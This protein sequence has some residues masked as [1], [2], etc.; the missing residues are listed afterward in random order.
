MS[1]ARRI[2]PGR[3]RSLLAPMAGLPPHPKNARTVRRAGPPGIG[4]LAVSLAIALAPG[5]AR[6]AKPAADRIG[7]SVV[8]VFA[9]LRYPNPYQPWTKRAPQDVSG[10][11][12][13][14]EG[15]RILTNAHVVMYGSDI[16]VQAGGA[17]DKIPATVAAMA[18]GIDLAVLTLQDKSF[19][20]GHPPLPRYAIIPAIKD[21]VTVYGYPLGGTTLSIT[22]GIVS[23]IEFAMY[24]FPVAGLRIQ[25]D[26]AL[27]HGNSGGPAVVDGR[28]IGLA[29][30]RLENGAQNI[31]YIIPTEE[32]DLFLRGI[33]DG[34]YD[35]K[36]AIYDEFQTLNN[37]T[38][39]A[40]LKLP[41][42]VHGV[43]VTEPYGD[44]PSY[45]LKRWDVVTKIG[46]T[47]LDDQGMIDTDTGLHLAFNYLVQ[48]LAKDGHVPLTIWRDGRP[49]QIELPVPT[50]RAMVVPDLDGKYPS[51]FIYGPLVFSE[52]TTEFLAALNANAGLANYLADM[53]SP[54]ETRRLDKPAFPGERLV[55]VSSPFFPSPLGEGYSNPELGVVKTV[56]GVRIK[57][58]RHLVEVL[59][60]TKDKFI[61]IVFYGHERESPVFRRAAMVAATNE[62]LNDNNV[63]S[64]GSPDMMAVW[65]ARPATKSGN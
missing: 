65:N 12:V 38:L 24:H 63:R 52:A 22:Q 33:A 11:G 42:D 3:P 4:V 7:K 44:G 19:F 64:Q 31:G 29:F 47:P 13:V 55:V 18:P 36:P 37:A 62:I 57:N 49:R 28:M 16:Q 14:I 30:S 8:K 60:D 50:R 39:R 25:I 20:A 2:F 61:S 9:T 5:A 27:N 35:G 51:Y 21:T 48:K 53:D 40:Y 43:M 6:A 45:P 41:S 17:G 56:N 54:L 10:S 59:R 23:R 34:H 26:A 15:D 1:R 32:I 46:E 58:L